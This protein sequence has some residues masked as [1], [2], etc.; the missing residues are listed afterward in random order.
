MTGAAII[1]ALTPGPRMLAFRQRW[2]DKI[3]ALMMG[4]LGLLAL[5]TIGFAGAIAFDSGR[6]AS[7]ARYVVIALSVM[8]TL[9]VGRLLWVL[10]AL[11]SIANRETTDLADTRPGMAWSAPVI[12]DGDFSLKPTERQAASAVIDEDVV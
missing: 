1:F 5:C 3:N 9:R 2:G 11:L 10:V 4:S 8:A 12:Y 6:H 7:G